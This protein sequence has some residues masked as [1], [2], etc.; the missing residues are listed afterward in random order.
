M[1][2]QIPSVLTAEQVGMFR[3]KP[4]VAAWSDGRITAGY[5]MWADV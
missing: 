1:L 2:I 4:E 5:R 3:A